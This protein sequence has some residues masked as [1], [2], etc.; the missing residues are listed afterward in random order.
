MAQLELTFILA[1]VY[2]FKQFAADFPLQ[3]RYMLQKVNP[4]WSFVGPLTVHCL[5]HA[6]MTLIICWV[7]NPHLWWLCGVDFVSHF[8]MDRIKAS[9][10]L[11][12][13]FTRSDGWM[14]WFTFGFDQMVHH[15]THLYIIWVLVLSI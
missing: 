7:V 15:L 13:R 9:P 6:A 11:L 2:Q 8:I 5:V 1:V 14:Y 12:G 3:T 4:G 10:N